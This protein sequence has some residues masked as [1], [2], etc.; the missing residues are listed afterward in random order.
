MVHII[1]WQH[2]DS[3]HLKVIYNELFIWLKTPSI[4]GGNSLSTHWLQLPSPSLGR[5][6]RAWKTQIPLGTLWPSESWSVELGKVRQR[7]SKLQESFYLVYFWMIPLRSRSIYLS[8]CSQGSLF[9]SLPPFPLPPSLPLL[10]LLC[11]HP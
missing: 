11:F 10:S 3:T 6:S 2:G 1:G 7:A 9:T 5:E 8:R 4:G